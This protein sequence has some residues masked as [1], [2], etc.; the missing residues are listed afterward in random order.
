MSDLINT[1][2]ELKHYGVLGMRWG[3]RK[4]RTSAQY[5]SEYKKARK[6]LAKLDSKYTKQEAKTLRLQSES[7]KQLNK[8]D[9][10]ASTRSGKRKA[11]KKLEK[12]MPKLN[13]AKRKTYKAAVKG[14]KWCKAME[15]HFSTVDIQM[16]KEEVAIGKKFVES[17]RLRALR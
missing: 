17:I 15:K 12:I 2:G 5:Q 4:G 7:D 10:W 8:M 14:E 13:K 1:D 16:S 11:A 6:K 9:S 3:V